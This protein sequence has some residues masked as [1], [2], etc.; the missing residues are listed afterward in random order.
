MELLYDEVIIC[1]IENL[2]ALLRTLAA[3]ISSI[4]RL[5]KKLMIS[6]IVPF[7]DDSTVFEDVV[8]HIVLCCP[9][10]FHLVVDPSFHPLSIEG[11][12]RA[13]QRHNRLRIS[14]ST[15]GITHLVWG[16]CLPFHDLIS[17]LQ[18][19]P[20]VESLRLH[21]PDDSNRPDIERALRTFLVLPHHKSLHFVSFR[22][23]SMYVLDSRI[24]QQWSMPQ[25]QRLTYGPH[26]YGFS[27]IV[28]FCQIHGHLLLYLHMGPD[29]IDWMLEVAVQDVLDVCPS[30]E[31][32]VIWIIDLEYLDTMVS[33]PKIMWLDFW[34]DMSN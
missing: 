3:P 29:L 28:L 10:L 32:S 15:A 31:H 23:G 4:G 1:R 13:L 34:L 24:R 16:H 9:S 25:L 14:D 12:S 18:H 27:D 20:N 26:S 5:I 11:Q 22:R 21:L 2:S 8:K 17:I 30:L 19:C 33:H 7:S 6:C